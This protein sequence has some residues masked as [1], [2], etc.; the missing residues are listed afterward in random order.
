MARILETEIMVDPI[1]VEAYAN[2]NKNKPIQDFLDKFLSKFPN[3]DGKSIADIGCGSGD[4]YA[5]LV[6]A[7][8][9]CNFV[10]YDASQPMLDIA[11]T[12]I[13]PAK[14]TLVNKN[15][16]TDSFDGRT[17]DGVISTMTLH[18]LH[19]PSKF[20]NALKTICKPG[21]FFMVMDLLRVENDKTCDEIVNNDV[22]ID[23]PVFRK[24]FKS[25]LKAAFLINEIQEQLNQAEISAQIETI[26][27]PDGPGVVFVYGNL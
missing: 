7:F 10:G 23:Y 3:A 26:D 20:W 15:I 1:E 22:S 18:Q 14:V 9:N 13:D 25:S 24:L 2:F 8:P 11:A 6:N 12:R 4:Y 5:S 17:F 21:G 16:N 27:F 19:D